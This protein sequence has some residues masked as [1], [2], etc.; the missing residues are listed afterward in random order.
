MSGYNKLSSLVVV[1][2]AAAIL[3]TLDPGSA[4]AKGGGNSK[5]GGV[6]SSNGSS[7]KGIGNSS[8]AYKKF[9]EPK[10]SKKPVT[11]SFKKPLKLPVSNK[12]GKLP[13][14]PKNGKKPFC[15]P[16][17]PHFCHH[18]FCCHRHWHWEFPWL[19]SAA[20]VVEVDAAPLYTLY[21]ETA[22]GIKVYGTYSMP[23]DNDDLSTSEQTLDGTNTAWW[24]VSTDGQLVDT[25]TAEASA[26]A[27]K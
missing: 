20:D 17:D 14:S 25:N 9:G 12:S 23:G 5:Q 10:F 15:N 22:D 11:K 3:A 24:L 7:A 1:C 2:S 6:K 19:I 13:I 26:D 27:T 8:A 21:Y 16:L 18:N 4:M